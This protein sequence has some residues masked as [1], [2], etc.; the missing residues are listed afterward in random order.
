MLREPCAWFVKG[1]CKF[2][3]NCALPH[4]LPKARTARAAS[5]ESNMVVFISD[6]DETNSS[7]T[8]EKLAFSEEETRIEASDRW[9]RAFVR[10]LN[11][12]L[13][14]FIVRSRFEWM[15]LV[16]QNLRRE[17]SCRKIRRLLEQ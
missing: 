11:G 15:K 8:P 6:D 7:V 3:G 16:R 5:T 13:M 2:G 4:V 14:I 1:K 12:V 17:A 10:S 9:D